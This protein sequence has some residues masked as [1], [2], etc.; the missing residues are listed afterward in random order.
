MRADQEI[1]VLVVDD[2][3]SLRNVLVMN[4]ELE[5]FSVLSASGGI[6]ALKIVKEKPLIDFV[7]TDIRMAEGGGLWLLQELKKINPDIPVVC[8]MTGFADATKEE[9][10][11][12][13]GIDLLSKPLN[14]NLIYQ[15]IREYAR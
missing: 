15:Y 10:L 1:T 12:N 6:E 11:A 13:G 2:D 14:M 5:G 3:L 7:L 4:L 9:I 8:L